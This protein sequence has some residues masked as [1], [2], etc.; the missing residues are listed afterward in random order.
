[1]ART[2][3]IG[4]SSL[5][6]NVLHRRTRYSMPLIGVA[7]SSK[8]WQSPRRAAA[9]A[10]RFRRLLARLHQP[11]PTVHPPRHRLHSPRADRTTDNETR[12]AKSEDDTPTPPQCCAAAACPFVLETLKTRGTRVPPAPFALSAE[13]AAQAGTQLV[14]AGVWHARADPARCI[15]TS[16]G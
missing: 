5:T 10:P 11:S 8:L 3:E 15:A 1:M 13:R 14:R 16:N 12:G 6:N 9:H 4:A 7:P 2:R